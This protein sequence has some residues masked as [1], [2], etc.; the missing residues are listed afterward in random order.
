MYRLISQIV[1]ECWSM[2]ID[3]DKAVQSES[4]FVT[5]VPFSKRKLLATIFIG[6]QR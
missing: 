3:P 1:P 6:V 4:S 5:R 2:K